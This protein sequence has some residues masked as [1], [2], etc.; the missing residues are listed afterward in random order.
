MTQQLRPGLCKHW[1]LTL[2]NPTITKD[3]LIA[4]MEPK[5]SYGVF[6]AEIGEGVYFLH[7]EDCPQSRSIS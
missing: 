1:C 3:E 2:N 6:Q 4:I 5:V 7:S